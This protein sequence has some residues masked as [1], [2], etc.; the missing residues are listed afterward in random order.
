MVATLL[1]GS[2][3]F[4]SCI[5][6]FKVTKSLWSWNDGVGSKFL[7]EVVFLALHIIP[8]Y[9][10]AYLADILIFNTIDFWGAGKGLA[11]V[12]HVK[13]EKGEYTIASNENGYHITNEAEKVSV[14][15]VFEEATKT[16]FVEAN[17]QSA[18][19]MTLIDDSNVLMYL[20]NEQT[21]EV[22]L[23][24][25]GYMAFRQAVESATLFASK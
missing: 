10:V 11:S 8:V 18:K 17:G 15:L 4:S 14:D 9:E 5:G 23:S 25:A 13:G 21:M 24:Q 20:G 7:N 22:E 12:Q 3:M 2:M 1:A 19:L 16:W 6:P